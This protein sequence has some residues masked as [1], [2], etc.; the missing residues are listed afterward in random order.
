MEH[1]QGTFLKDFIS[2][3]KKMTFIADDPKTYKK[4]ISDDNV[5]LWKKTMIK[6]LADLNKLKT[7]DLMNLSPNRKAINGRWT[8]V[9]KPK[10][11][12]NHKKKR[13]P[14]G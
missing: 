12:M 1:D 6:H 9:T 11:K 3:L 2:Q 14:D 5:H 8:Y 13:R 4:T 10:K 7:W